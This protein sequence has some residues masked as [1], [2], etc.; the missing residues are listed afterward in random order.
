MRTVVRNN[1]IQGRIHALQPFLSA[2]LLPP[3]EDGIRHRRCWALS[4][5]A[6][7]LGHLPAQFRESARSALYTVYSYGTPIAWVT[8]AEDS[9]A[10]HPYVYHIPNVGYSP[11]TGQHQAA[12]ACAWWGV[13]RRQY[14]RRG[15]DIRKFDLDGP[16][17]VVR[18]PPTAEVYGTPRRPRS[19]GMDGVRPGETVGPRRSSAYEGIP[20]DDAMHWDT[21]FTRF[22]DPEPGR[23]TPAHP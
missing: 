7:E 16:R 5:P 20:G 14:L 19:G 13:R 10:P 3:G 22:H 17:V 2:G 18:V 23:W 9:R 1:E 15:S 12:A 11:T 8:E 4:G 6:M 21:R